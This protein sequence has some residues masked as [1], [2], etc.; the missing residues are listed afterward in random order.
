MRPVSGAPRQATVSDQGT[1]GGNPILAFSLLNTPKNF[2]A[3]KTALAFEKWTSL[4]SD[5]HILSWV[6]GVHIDFTEHLSQAAPPTPIQFSES[7]QT[8]IN[9]EV[10]RLLHKDIIELTHPSEGQFISNIFFRPKKDG[11]IRLIL[12]L[13]TLN[14]SVA[15]HHFKMETLQAAIQLMSQGCFLAS[16]DLKDAYYSVPVAREDRKYLRFIWKGH[17]FQFTCLP[18]GL[19]EAPRKFTKLLK[20]PFAHLRKQ[21]HLSSAYIDDSCL[22]GHS[23]QAC[24]ENVQNTVVLMDELGFTVHPQKS[25]F[26]PTHSL[27]YLGFILN[28]LLMTVTLTEEKREKITKMCGDLLGRKVCTIRTL[29]EVIGNLVASEPGVDLAPL[30]YK[31][32]EI[33]KDK[34]LKAN[35]GD[36]EATLQIP[37]NIKEDL[38]WWMENLPLVTRHLERPSPTIVIHTDSSDKAWGAVWQKQ[39]VGGPWVGQEKEWH[40]NYKEL[41]AAFFGLRAFCTN[42][43]HCHVQIFVDNTTALAYINNQGGRKQELNELAR[44]IWLWASDKHIWLSA[45]HTPGINNIE[46]D[47]ASRQSYAQEAEWQLEKKVFKSIHEQYGPIQMD[48]FASRANAQCNHYVSWKPDPFAVAVDAFSISWVT[49]GLYAFPPF[50]VIGRVIN[51][52]AKEG[53]TMLIVLPLWPNQPWFPRALHMSI[54]HPRLLPADP[55]LLQLPQDPS[56]SHPLIHKLHLTLFRLSGQSG[57]VRDFQQQLPLWSH[58]AGGA[59]PVSSTKPTFAN[60]AHFAVNGRYLQCRPLQRTW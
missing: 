13:K 1:Q 16:V 60:G 59:L 6:K 17:L 2:V 22:L 56:K 39:P 28:S 42:T 35:R 8:K 57:K 15:Y 37:S 31:R 40:I 53:A 50:S 26:Q 5:S 45:V 25:C 4:T 52:L 41:M 51:K 12:N 48:L 7:D 27:V 58:R 20:V 19:A 11:A 44:S 36:Y 54:D 43:S 14:L 32:L 24:R 3:G 18:N 29:A 23:Q 30:H 38:M 46:A 9:D 10:Q 34:A 55:G 49:H 21:G 33:E 47:R